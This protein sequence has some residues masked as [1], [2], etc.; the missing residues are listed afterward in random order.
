MPAWRGGIS[1]FGLVCPSCGEPVRRRAGSERRPHFAHFSNRAKPD[2][3]NYFPPMGP[4]V[5]S[6]L[7]SVAGAVRLKRESLSCGLFLVHQQE[8]NSLTL[9]LRIPSV[10]LGLT[11]TGSLEIQSGL[12]HHTY[13]VADLRTAR[14]VP[15]VP[16]Y[17]LAASTGSGAL[18]PLAAHVS[19]QVGAFAADLNLFC[20]EEKGG[21][22][23]FSDEPLEWGSRYRL[24]ARAVIAPPDE[25]GALLDWKPGQKFGA[26]NSYEV[27]LPLAFAAS[28]PQVPAQISQFLGRPIRYGRPRLFVVQPSPHHIDIDGTYV[29]PEAPG[30]I[31]LRRSASGKVT[32]DTPLG[33]ALTAVSELADEWVRVEGLPVDGHDCTVSIDGNE[34]VVIRVEACELFRPTGLIANSG[35]VQWDLCAEAPIA[36]A[37]LLRNEVD[38]ECGSVRIAAHFLKMNDG[39][40]QQGSVLSSPSGAAKVLYAGSFGELR[41][42]VVLPPEMGDH[43]VQG[44]IT[45]RKP[46]RATRRWVEGLVIRNFGQ[47]GLDRVRRY[48][49]DPSRANLHRLGLIM[50]SPL[51]PYIRAAHDQERGQGA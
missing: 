21:R 38:V 35:D 30:S 7:R 25:L 47:E 3:E 5:A 20:A 33:S 12:G 15:L 28:R 34:Q 40:L 2:C 50:T 32:V 27:T 51:M 43:P 23:V 48:F 49:A 18:L 45:R 41:S 22:F 14:L 36:P 9:W 1:G 44:S 42:V 16:Q 46:P 26:W 39:W 6:S 29:Y 31:L 8:R 10:E 11:A 13:R 19:G 37:E 17:P 24:L 4:A